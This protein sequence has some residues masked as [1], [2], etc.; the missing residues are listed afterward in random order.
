MTTLNSKALLKDEYTK[1]AIDLYA[2]LQIN[3]AQAMTLEQIS[4]E[5]DQCQKALTSDNTLCSSYYLC[6]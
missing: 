2:K 4:Q 6:R 3:P 5:Y 1:K